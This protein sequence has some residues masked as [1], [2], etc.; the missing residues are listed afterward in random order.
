[1]PRQRALARQPEDRFEDGAAFARALREYLTAEGIEYGPGDCA[2]E[3]RWL[4]P[5]ESKGRY[6][7]G[8]D[9]W[10][11]RPGDNATVDPE[12]RLPKADRAPRSRAWVLGAAVSAG[13]VLVASWGVS[14][15]G[16]RHAPLVEHS[17]GELTKSCTRS[18]RMASLGI[19]PRT[20][21]STPRNV[22]NQPHPMTV[23]MRGSVSS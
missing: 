13:A 12:E 21:I 18:G 7:G 16:L 4:C 10:S 1:M 3:L 14:R 22:Y 2:S 23:G 9:A 15:L 19:A 11:A 6:A 5:G 17:A 8:T 20:M